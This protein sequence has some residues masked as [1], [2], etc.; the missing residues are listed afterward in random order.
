MRSTSIRQAK[1]KVMMLMKLCTVVNSVCKYM[2]INM[3]SFRVLV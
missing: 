3:Y 2:V 1:P